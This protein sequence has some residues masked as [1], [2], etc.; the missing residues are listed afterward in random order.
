VST[1]GTRKADPRSRVLA[2]I[3]TVPPGR[4]AALQAVAAHIAVAERVVA[5]MIA[6]L[7]ADELRDVPWHRIVHAGGAVG[8]HARRDLQ[9]ARLR[10]EGVPVAPAGVVGD[11]A[12]RLV[13]IPVPAE[14]LHSGAARVAPAAAS[15]ARARIDR[16]RSTVG[17]PGRHASEAA[18]EPVLPVAGTAF[19]RHCGEVPERP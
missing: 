1:D 10:A 6:G 19:A 2:V 11:L 4:V 7:D 18:A 17:A 14:A 16:P 3:A 8:R 13:P 5:G 9:V 12:D 15:G